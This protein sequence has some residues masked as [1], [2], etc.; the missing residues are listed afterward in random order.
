MPWPAM[1]PDMNLIENLWEYV[2]RRMAELEP[3][4][5]ADLKSKIMQAWSEIP[6]AVCQ[7]YAMSFANYTLA[8]CQSR[9]EHTKY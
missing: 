4:N 2:K 6:L 5:I 7:K 8:L 1:S 3:K 9:G